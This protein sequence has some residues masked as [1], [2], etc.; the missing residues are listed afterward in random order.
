MLSFL[1]NPFFVFLFIYNCI[2]TKKEENPSNFPKF[3][4]KDLKPY[5]YDKSTYIIDTRDMDIIVTGYIPNSIITPLSLYSWLSAV[6]PE[7]ANVIIITDEKNKD[8]AIN[9]TLSLN[10]YNIKGYAIYDEVINDISFNPQI[11]EYNPNTIESI[12]EIIEKGETIIDIREISE[13]KETGV[14]KEATLVPLR[15]FQMNY[16]KVPKKGNIYVY[17]KSGLRAIIG[18]SYIKRAGYKNKFIIMKG[19]MNKVIE[20]GYPLVPYEE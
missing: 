20:Q 7:K 5:L 1:L 8:K 9:Q 2:L 11:V 4:G 19:G 18:M 6:V 15:S 14:I 16:S 10:L 13:Y 17:C 12:K 3:S